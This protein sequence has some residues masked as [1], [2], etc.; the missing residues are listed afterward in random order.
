LEQ[1]I[2]IVEDFVLADI[3]FHTVLAQ[4][5]QNPLMPMLLAPISEPLHDLSSRASSLSG[6]PQDA[7]KHHKKILSCVKKHDE[8]A[9][10]R[11]MR[12]HLDSTARWGELAA[13][14]IPPEEA[15]EHLE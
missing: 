7:L 2:D 3:A 15:E 10:R 4:A 12:D 11:A 1:N 13:Q 14:Q 5:S 9:A 8:Q 6:A